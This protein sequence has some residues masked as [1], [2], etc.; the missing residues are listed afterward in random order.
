MDFPYFIFVT[1]SE[2]FAKDGSTSV[3]T[4]NIPPLKRP[5]EDSEEVLEMREE[6][7]QL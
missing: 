5:R 7:R 2:V 6:V 3:S 4:V 1:M